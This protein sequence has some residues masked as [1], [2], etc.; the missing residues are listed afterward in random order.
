ML[1][2]RSSCYLL[3]L[4]CKFLLRVLLLLP[5]FGLGYCSMS[6]CIHRC[7]RLLL[8]SLY[9]FSRRN[10]LLA[11]HSL[12]LLRLLVGLLLPWLLLRSS[13][14][15]LPLLCK[16]LL[17]VLLP[18]PSFVLGYCSMSMCI[19]RCLRLLLPLLYHFS[20]R[21]TLLALMSLRLLRLLVELLLLLL[22]L[23]S[24]CYLLP[25][26]CKFLLPSPSCRCRCL[27]WAAAP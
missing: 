23:R 21:N 1:L 16:C 9:R 8:L 6:M 13:C 18:L 24:S 27:D 22:L 25:L 7:L 11:L 15:L 17:R 14:Y 2:L 12:P 5:S 3:P 4:L 19:H 20:L 10:T 26:L